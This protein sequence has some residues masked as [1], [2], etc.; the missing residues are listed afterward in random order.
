MPKNENDSKTK[1]RRRNRLE[2]EWRNTQDMIQCTLVHGFFKAKAE[3]WRGMGYLLIDEPDTV[4]DQLARLRAGAE[5]KP[6]EDRMVYSPFARHLCFVL[7]LYHG[8]LLLEL[9]EHQ[10][11]LVFD[12]LLGAI[13]NDTSQDLDILARK[14]NR[15]VQAALFNDPAQTVE[16]P[17]LY[18]VT[19]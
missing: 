5:L 14:L 8:V 18:L 15:V 16:R 12:R 6:W 9:S 10:V 19:N 13:Q 3:Y 7:E 4:L 17:R 2:S 11:Q 1:I